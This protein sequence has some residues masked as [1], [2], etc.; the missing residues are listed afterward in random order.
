MLRGYI[1]LARPVNLVIALA[2]IF[3]GGFVTGT[4]QPLLKLLLA[5]AS[6]TLIAA[7]ANKVV[8]NLDEAL[9]RVKEVAGPINARRHATKH[10]MDCFADLPCVRTGTCNDCSHPERICRY[11]IIIE[12]ERESVKGYTPR[13]HLIIIGEEL[14]I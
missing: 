13:I 4:V 10:K 14:G 9:K 11:T 7:G 5:C 6:G 12:G 3:M 8:R 2:S 1:L